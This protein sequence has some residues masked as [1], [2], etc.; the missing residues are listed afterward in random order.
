MKKL[1]YSYLIAII[2]KGVLLVP[3][4]LVYGPE[5][6][7]EGYYYVPLFF[8]NKYN[9]RINGFTPIYELDILRVIYEVGII[10]LI[11]YVIYLILKNNNKIN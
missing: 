4:Y 7:I 9:H 2:V 8:L 11:F 10:T 6:S 1:L 5:K 3:C